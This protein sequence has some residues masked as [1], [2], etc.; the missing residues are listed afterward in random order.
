MGCVLVERICSARRWSFGICEFNQQSGFSGRE[1][2]ISLVDGVQ[3][4]L[5]EF[6]TTSH[7]QITLTIDTQALNHRRVPERGGGGEGQGSVPHSGDEQGTDLSVTT[8]HD[9]TILISS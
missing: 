6:P 1:T 7:R 5:M 2:G 9:E 8:G 4:F 3:F